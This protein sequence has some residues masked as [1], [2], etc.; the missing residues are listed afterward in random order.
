MP[1]DPEDPV[2]SFCGLSYA[3][4]I[5]VTRTLAQSMPLGWQQRF[6]QCLEELDQACEHLEGLPDG[7]NVRARDAKNQAYKDPY[8]DYQRGR[9]RVEL[10]PPPEASLGPPMPTDLK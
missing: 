6:A 10:T 4:Y 5:V 1:F 9:R 7:Y 2:H 8:G 3:N